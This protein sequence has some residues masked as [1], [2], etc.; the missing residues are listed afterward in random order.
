[1][2][3]SLFDPTDPGF[4]DDPYPAYRRLRDQDPVHWDEQHNWWVLSRYEECVG[5]L[6]DPRTFASDWRRIGIDTPPEFVSV[7]TLDPPQHTHVRRLLTRAIGGVNHRALADDVAVSVG[8]ILDELVPE[9]EFDFVRA[10]ARPVAL[11]AVARL[12]GNDPGDDTFADVADAVV[13]SMDLGLHPD[14]ERD[15]LD[16]RRRMDRLIE[17]WF[18]EASGDGLINQL[19]S[20]RESFENEADFVATLHSVRVVFFSVYE[21]WTRFMANAMLHLLA[22]A[23]GS[24]D[25][26]SPSQLPLDPLVEEL[27]RFDGPVQ[28]ESRAATEDVEIGGRRISK[29]DL[30]VALLGSA[31]RDP[32]RFE[33]PD[34]ILP[35]RHPNPHVGFGY[36]VHSCP[37]KRFSSICS[38]AL[39]RVL[40]ERCPGLNV[41]RAPDRRPDATLR[42]LR[43]LMLAA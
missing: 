30:V 19:A 12:L 35:T 40:F 27:L 2:S 32:S 37:G 18:D 24:A 41:T 9:G 36:G 10:L 39:L 33:T 6:G 13:R 5:V 28:A 43:S 1:M 42:G 21:S 4:L 11:R 3:Q 17:E 25:L 16:A 31:N 38:S 8:R 29:G 15:G 22:S 26:R 7:Q 23:D 14:A 34:M 20:A